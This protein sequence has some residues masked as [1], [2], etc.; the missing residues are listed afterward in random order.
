MA[1]RSASLRESPFVTPTDG[2][3]ESQVAF[4][5]AARVTILPHELSSLA[6]AS[7]VDL[8]SGFDATRLAPTCERDRP[9]SDVSG[10]Y[11][12]VASEAAR[13]LTS[14][15]KSI[16][17]RGTFAQPLAGTGGL[18]PSAVGPPEGGVP[19]SEGSSSGAFPVVA[20]AAA[21][22]SAVVIAIIVVIVV[23]ARRAR[24]S[25]SSV[26]SGRSG[27]CGLETALA[28]TRSF[29]LTMTTDMAWTASTCGGEVNSLA[30]DDFL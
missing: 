21:I 1:I 11:S 17:S 14:A 22:A 6:L 4:E 13:L 9:S 24:G 25:A 12:L 3:D 27:N 16:D 18:E 20:V 19:S 15:S 8:G 7:D 5:T 10:G 28:A 30:P 26:A 29:G 23:L 2:L